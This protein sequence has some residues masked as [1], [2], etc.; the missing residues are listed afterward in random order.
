ML[1]KVSS[2][3]HSTSGQNSSTQAAASCI[4]E[5][6]DHRTVDGV[7]SVDTDVGGLLEVPKGRLKFPLFAGRGASLVFIHGE[8]SFF[9]PARSEQNGE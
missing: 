8:S 5:D 1:A 3:A 4:T 9:L 7:F 6:H 2:R